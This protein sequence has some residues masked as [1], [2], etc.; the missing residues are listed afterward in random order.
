M[1]ASFLAPAG[2]APTMVAGRGSAQAGFTLVEVAVAASLFG[3]LAVILFG[4]LRFGIRVMDATGQRSDFSA[5]MAATYD[6][7]RNEL[8]QAQPMLTASRAEVLAFDGRPDGVDFVTLMPDQ[9]AR[10]GY[11][12]LSIGVA[13]STSSQRLQAEWK[14]FERIGLPSR[15]DDVPH[16]SLL[17][18][19]LTVAEFSYF[20][21]DDPNALGS[22]HP[23]WQGHRTLPSLVRIR[24]QQRG[25]AAVHEM[26]V[27][28]RLAENS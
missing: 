25:Q 16:E 4:G 24:L 1:T 20:G 21:G 7:V 15:E 3:L 18:D 22:W 13:R 10:G 23:S 19:D 14:P 17:V 9:I 27:A 6:F 26:T 8:G 28:L 2:A 5:Q 11:Q 12:V